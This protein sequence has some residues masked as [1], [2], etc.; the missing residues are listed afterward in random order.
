MTHGETPSADVVPPEATLLIIGSGPA[1]VSAA[2]SYADSGGPGTVLIVT[3]DADRPYQ[4]PPLSKEMLA[5]E[6][7]VHP[8]PIEE[9]GLPEQVSLLLGTEVTAVDRSARTVLCRTSEGMRSIRY[10]Q[11]VMALGS[12]PKPLPGVEDGARVHLLRSLRQAGALAEAAAG[13]RSAVVVGSGF[14]GCEAAASLAARGVRTTMV[15]PEPTPQAARLGEKAGAHVADWL[16][17]AG[18]RVLAGTQVEA[19]RA[20]CTVRLDDGT[21]IPADLVLAAVG[22]EQNGE[23]PDAAGFPT[24]EGRVLVDEQLRAGAA[25]WAAGD[26]AE[27]RHAVA[28]RRLAVEHWGDALSM[29]EIAGHN[30]AAALTRGA[31]PRAWDAVPGFWSVIGDRTLKYA[32]W[33]DGYSTAHPVE[34]DDGFTVWYAD[35]EG[36]LVGVLTHQADEDYERG[37]ELIERRSTVEEALRGG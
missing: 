34:H 36:V 24:E 20:P 16:R 19:V 23:V 6:Q 25:E 4:R 5:G 32:A 11:L 12:R 30:A 13:A 27:A 21:E 26:L 9:E 35:A 31:E 28:G 22:V 15:T 37:S 2:R 29:G 17:G 14:I 8:Q 10:S 7:P 33:G 18:V 1:G 3:A